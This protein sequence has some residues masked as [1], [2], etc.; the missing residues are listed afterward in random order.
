MNNKRLMI[1]VAVVLSVLFSILYFIVFEVY[2]PS[3][4][5]AQK[6]TLYYN[7][8]GLYKEEKNA[9]KVA[10]TLK[11]NSVEAY[12][13]KDKDIFVIVSGVS[14]K[15]KQTIENGEALKKS[16]YSYLLKKVKVQDTTISQCIK[17]KEYQKALELIANQS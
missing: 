13:Y 15:E 2:I 5:Q 12:I 6:M 11:E 10:D 9:T 3:T 7:Q 8:I 1:I 4:S 16:S 17:Q 14:D